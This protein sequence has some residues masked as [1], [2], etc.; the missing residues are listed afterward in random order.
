[1]TREQATEIEEILRDYYNDRTGEYIM[2]EI[3]IDGED[4]SH[5]YDK[6]F[7]IEYLDG[8]PDFKI[9]VPVIPRLVREQAINLILEIYNTYKSN[10]KSPFTD[11][12]WKD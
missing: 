7:S 6:L 4:V 10:H 8:I 5:L 9:S 2:P 3:I 1:M 12:E 11:K